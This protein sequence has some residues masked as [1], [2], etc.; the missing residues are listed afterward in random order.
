MSRSARLIL[1][2]ALSIGAFLVG[3]E[4]MITA[5][6]LPQILNDLADWTE[7]PRA[8]WIINGY[9]L[10]YVATM[11]LAGRAA[12]RFHLPT[13]FALA[14]GLFAVGSLLCGAAQDLDWLIG[15]RIVQG[16]G[17][18][19]ILPLATA[20]ASHLFAGPA[21]ARAIGVV[22]ALTF[23][24]M[25][26]GPFLGATILQSV[27]LDGPALVAPAWRWVF[28]VGAPFA[29]LAA[30]YTWAAAPRWQ[31][32][33]SNQQIDVLGAALFTT[34]I[35]TGLLALTALGD[36]PSPGVPG[37]IELSVISILALALA[38]ARFA[39]ARHPFLELRFFANRAFSGAVV[40]SLLTGYALATALIGG[41][42]FIDRV[43]YGLADEQQLALGALAGAVAIGALGSGLALRRV[44]I[45]LVSLV[46]LAASIGGLLAL[47]GAGPDSPFGLLVGG[48]AAFGFGF[49]LTITARSTAAIEALGAS[50]F[51][52]ASASV[53]VARMIGMA[54]GLAALTG[55]GSRRIEALSLVLVD[56]QARDAVL[57]EALRGRPL[58]DYL[59]VDALEA[60]AASQA[61]TILG[62]LFLIAAIVTAV[63]IL[64]TLAM[65]GQATGRDEMPEDAGA[66][67]GV[68]I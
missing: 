30:L 9:L 2:G 61:A 41:A 14:L 66:R 67:A 28:Y 60:W 4:L 12:D 55:F 21:R 20:G 62:G 26:A 45:I 5:V 10:A 7:L 18:G 34:A 58:Q 3:V 42:V 49:G 54:V 35:A 63:A 38:V 22:G 43:R 64:P 51:G 33:T 24:G 52:L 48:L 31:R 19:A 56:Q 23:L 25:A 11:P 47:A 32:G 6:A 1:L 16:V 50:A 68:A 37:P 53:T 17:A 15:A 57:P 40:L 59:V 8:S 27:Q 13:L 29:L 65:G 39:L 46:G 36:D 44:G